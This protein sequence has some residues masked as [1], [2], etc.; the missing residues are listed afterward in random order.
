MFKKKAKTDIEF[1]KRQIGKEVEYYKAKALE[2]RAL[3]E[4]EEEPYVKLVLKKTWLQYNNCAV[5]MEGIYWH[6]DRETA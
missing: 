3:Y 1:I 6:F 2:Y 4:K 5:E